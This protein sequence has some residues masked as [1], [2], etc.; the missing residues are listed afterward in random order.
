MNSKQYNCWPTSLLFHILTKMLHIDHYIS[1]WSSKIDWLKWLTKIGL[2]V[3][4]HQLTLQSGN[5]V[6]IL[7][8]DGLHE[9]RLSRNSRKNLAALEVREAES[10]IQRFRGNI[11]VTICWRGISAGGDYSCSCQ[12]DRWW[13]WWCLRCYWCWYHVKWQQS[14]QSM[15]SYFFQ[16]F[17]VSLR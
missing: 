5:S 17:G 1:L 10:R 11:Q 13:W 8:P 3:A 12:S 7:R 6:R 16:I 4:L 15:F 14:I 2:S 9:G